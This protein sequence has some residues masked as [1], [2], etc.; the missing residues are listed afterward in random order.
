M[1]LGLKK[2][3]EVVEEIKNSVHVGKFAKN[4]YG[5]ISLNNGAGAKTVAV[6]TAIELAK[7]YKVC[8]VDCN[9]FQPGL[10]HTLNNQINKEDSLSR[11]LN[12]SVEKEKVFKTVSGVQNMWMV[13]A[14]PLDSPLDFIRVDEDTY[15]SLL[16]YIKESFDYV[17]AYMPY[18]PLSEMFAFTLDYLDRGYIVWDDQVDCGTKTAFLL[19]YVNDT[20]KKANE[21]NNVILNKL[22]KK[23]DYS[24]SLIK[25]VECNL[26]ATFPFNGNIPLAKNEGKIFNAK[27]MGDKDYLDNMKLLIDDI[28]NGQKYLGL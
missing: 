16:D 18:H 9:L 23:R 4:F 26:I 3:R 2:A 27:N 6:N 19:Q 21:I 17:I 12:S 22:P 14:S 25:N 1:A 10:C 8:L 7:D 28:K 24:V 20:S 15:K 11:Y 5:F 13:S